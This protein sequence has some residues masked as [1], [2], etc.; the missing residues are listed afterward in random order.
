M[1]SLDERLCPGRHPPERPDVGDD[2]DGMEVGDADVVDLGAALDGQHHPPVRPH[3]GL[4]GADR[5]RPPGAEW[6]ELLREYDVV[7][8]RDDG[9]RLDRRVAG[10][11]HLVSQVH[12]P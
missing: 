2:G 1:L 12:D 8:Q 3:R 11:P 6:R 5:P 9:E 4:E 10:R 7:A